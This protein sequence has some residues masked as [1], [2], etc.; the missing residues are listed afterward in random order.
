MLTDSPMPV[1]PVSFSCGDLAVVSRVETPDRQTVCRYTRTI[2]DV[3]R[4]VML[5]A[6]KET[7]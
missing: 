4:A 2:G 6:D 5:I 7:P 3:Q 1:L